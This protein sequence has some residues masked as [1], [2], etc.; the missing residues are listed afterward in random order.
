MGQSFLYHQCV[1]VTRWLIL[2]HIQLQSVNQRVLI[3]ADPSL[4]LQQ[5]GGKATEESGC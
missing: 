2:I 5:S 4:F 1:G 3:M